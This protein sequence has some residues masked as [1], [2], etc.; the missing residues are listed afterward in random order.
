M[1]KESLILI[2][3]LYNE[4]EVISHVLETW[5]T[6]L[7]KFNLNY[8]II[9]INDGS[10]DKSLAVAQKAASCLENIQI[11]TGENSG[12]G[13]AITKGY[14]IAIEKSPDWIFQCDSDDQISS[15]Q[16]YKLWNEREACELVLGNRKEREDP[17]L[18]IIGSN[19]LSLL[20]NS[21]FKLRMNDYNCPFR[22]I[23]TDLLRKFYQQYTQP[24]FAPN[25]FISIFFAQHSRVKS[26]QISHSMRR[27][28][29]P[30]LNIKGVF[31]AALKTLKN[32]ISFKQ[33]DKI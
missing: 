8:Q 25:I 19:A 30:S 21:L 1:P 16:F 27:T 20:L 7:S 26:I 10:R 14:Q 28:G 33:I 15:D 29:R 6:T 23:K 9:V 2:L 31:I 3:P 18:R 5:V 4:E 22:L 32:I 24:F 17:L 13:L 11:I 12:H